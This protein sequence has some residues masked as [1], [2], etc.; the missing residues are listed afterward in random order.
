MDTLGRTMSQRIKQIN[1]SW[2]VDQIKKTGRPCT[3][4]ELANVFG[5]SRKD[6][7]PTLYRMQEQGILRKVGDSPPRWTTLGNMISG[8]RPAMGRGRGRARR[9]P[10]PTSVSQPGYNFSTQTKP[11]FQFPV[12]GTGS[13]HTSP[14]RSSPTSSML[15]NP[16]VGNDLQRRLLKALRQHGRP[17]TAL[18]LARSVGLVAR[19]E[20]NPDLYRMEKVGLVDMETSGGPPKWSL[21]KQ[22]HVQHSS[23]IPVDTVQG[24]GAN[25][26][27]TSA[28][29][30]DDTMQT[31]DSDQVGEEMDV[32]DQT[33]EDE[34]PLAQLRVDL[35]HIPE[36]NIRDRLI[37]VMGVTPTV[38]RTDLELAKCIGDNYTRSKVR[39]F[40][41]QLAKE[42][43]VAK[44]PGFPTKWMISQTSAF[45]PPNP[46][47]PV[48]QHIAGSSPQ[49]VHTIT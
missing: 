37:A 27:S 30:I 42:G 10:T 2:V 34:S 5:V 22:A 44:S 3:T 29:F 12:S 33:S 32:D 18:E 9:S 7:N 21:S 20:V 16:T 17:Q 25:I 49:K 39:P 19:R 15:R 14:A 28:Q 45:Q 8:K 11:T 6:L 48:P 41:E 35:S 4:L 46:G 23:L 47:A 1:P 13:G 24:Q 31:E 43:R 38:Q 26:G 40:L 36:E